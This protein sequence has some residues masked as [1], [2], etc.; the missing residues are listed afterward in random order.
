MIERVL[1]IFSHNKLIY[2][3]VARDLQIRYKNSFLGYLWTLMDPLCTIA[4]FTMVFSFIFNINIEHYPIFLITGILPWQ[5]FDKCLS[6]SAG[7]LINHRPIIQKVN[8]PKEII[9]IYA[10]IFNLV[11]LMTGF[12]ILFS[13]LFFVDMPISKHIVFIPIV[14]VFQLFFNLGISFIVSILNVLFRD[15]A[16]ITGFALRLWFYATP[17]FYS[18]EMVPEKIYQFYMLNPMVTF[19]SSY[20]HCV[21][22]TPPPPLHLVAFTGCISIFSIVAGFTI[23]GKLERRML[24]TI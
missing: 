15:V 1:K 8:F 21:M 4:I 23:F 14:F 24:K 22:N 6:E 18:I 19:I 10:N 5:F 20:R 3:F 12:L 2:F 11:H 7:S 13:I 16:I 9:P 17:I